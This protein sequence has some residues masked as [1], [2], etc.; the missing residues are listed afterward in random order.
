MECRLDSGGQR[1][2]PPSNYDGDVPNMQESQDAISMI[3]IT[4]S[5]T[6]MKEFPSMHL[7]D[8]NVAH[9]K[10]KNLLAIGQS[11]F[12]GTLQQLGTLLQA[13]IVERLHCSCTLALD[14][15]I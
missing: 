3:S 4:T 7:V 6:R 8:V 15:C 9:V 11:F 1:C 13:C 10:S 14:E 5:M 2:C 12:P